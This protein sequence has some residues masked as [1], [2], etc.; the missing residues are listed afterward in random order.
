METL[1]SILH[2]MGGDDKRT[3]TSRCR[4]FVRHAVVFAVHIPRAAEMR[5]HVYGKTVSSRTFVNV[6][7]F[8]PGCLSLQ[9][10]NGGSLGRAALHQIDRRCR[11]FERELWFF[12]PRPASLR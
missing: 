9:T 5:L 6:V 8:Q 2:R 10:F 12:P 1:D 3:S 4:S 7:K 11:G